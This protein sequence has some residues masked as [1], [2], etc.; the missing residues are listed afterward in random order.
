M[1]CK[2]CNKKLKTKEEALKELK[3][4][5]E[6]N[7]VNMVGDLSLESAI[8]AIEILTKTGFCCSRE[9]DTRIDR[10]NETIC[11]GEHYIVRFH[12]AFL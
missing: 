6:T 8:A 10:K 4:A 2:C 9:N 7:D 5:I 12:G 1:K 3:I 11:D